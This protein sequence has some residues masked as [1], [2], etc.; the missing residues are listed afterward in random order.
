MV[1]HRG[2]HLL[3][4]H[5]ALW[6]DEGFQELVSTPSCPSPPRPRYQVYSQQ[7]TCLFNEFVESVSILSLACSPAHYST[8]DGASHDR[9]TALV[10]TRSVHS[11]LDKGS[12]TARILFLDFSSAFN[13]IQPLVLQ[14]K[15][16]QMRVD[17]CLVAWIS[18][19]LTD[20]PQF[21]RM[22]DITS[23]TVVSSIGA[24]QGTVLS[25][26]L[27][28]LYTSDFCYNSEMCHI[29]K[30]ADD[31]AIVGCIRDDEEEE[32]RCLVR[33]FVAWCHNNSLQL[34]TSKTKELVIDFGRDR[35]RPRPV[36]I[37]TEEVE[38]VQTYKYLGLWLDNR[39]DW[40][41]N[42]RQ[43]YKKTQSRMYFLRRLRSFNI[44]RKLLWM[45]YQSVVASVL[46]YAVV[47]WG[48]SVTKAD[49]SRLEKLIRR[50]SSVVGM[51]L[52][53]LATVAEEN[54]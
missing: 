35:P 34:N 6:C 9:L 15:L 30:F 25:P 21:V 42:T 3:L 29:Q 22:K 12:G 13:T 23:D 10:S 19:Y 7:Q 17:P 45:F 47:C 38:G 20:R 4:G 31:T 50:A 48:G 27:F 24:P 28:T 43:L 26:I 39:L 32:Y 2:A 41:S 16:L 53:P 36:Q 11:H 49:L 37:G 44:C 54:Y 33:D 52:K 14:D 5:V 51:K 40:T 46:S 18:T 1:R 8:E